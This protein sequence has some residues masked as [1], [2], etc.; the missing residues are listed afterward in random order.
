MKTPIVGKIAFNDNYHFTKKLVDKGLEAH[1][2]E[3]ENAQ[4]REVLKEINILAGIAKKNNCRQ[5]RD[6]CGRWI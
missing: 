6:I 3:A 2:L 1:C 5:I 4:L